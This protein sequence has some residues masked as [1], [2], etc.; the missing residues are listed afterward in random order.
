[1]KIALMLTGL[2]RKV[3]EGYEEYWKYVIDNN[4][5]DLYLHAWRNEP[6][7]KDKNENYNIISQIYP[8]YKYFC[9]ES[10][11]KFT[12][13]KENI[14]DI[15]NNKQ[16]N[17]QK[18]F[19]VDGNFRGFPMFYSWESTYQHVKNSNIKYDCVIRSRYDL[20]GKPLNLKE[21]NLNKIN[22]AVNHWYEFSINDDNLCVSS[23]NLSD[24]IFSNI[25][26]D[27]V[28]HC[29]ETNFM[30][31]PEIEFT[32]FLKRNNLYH[33]SYKDPNILF[34]LLRNDKE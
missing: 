24:K 10:P 13:Y 7:G 18:D 34:Y 25:F 31:Y 14:L 19:D 20:T 15:T 29:K 28:S 21:L 6:N 11:F 1:M 30:L 26:S 17:F 16:R 4:D 22:I 27:I 32:N 8:N 33:L 23:Q 9:V 2:A 12:K 3:K 5:V